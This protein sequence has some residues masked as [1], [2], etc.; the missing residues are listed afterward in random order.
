MAETSSGTIGSYVSK[1]DSFS[2]DAD[3]SQENEHTLEFIREK[4]QN[5]K[6]VQIKTK[7]ERSQN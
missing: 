6:S 5:L 7:R 3:T 4:E 1:T 2:V